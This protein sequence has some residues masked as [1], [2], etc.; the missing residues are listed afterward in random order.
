MTTKNNNN[1]LVLKNSLE[2]LSKPYKEQLNSYPN[3]VDVFD[4]VISDFGDA[5]LLLPV[6]MDEN[7]I[8]YEAVKEILKC[9]NLIDLNLSIEERR[10]DQSFES[11]QSWD[12]VRKLSKDALDLLNR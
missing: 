4:E 9:N 5:F 10:T 8:S 12:L 2:N 11:D 3:F 7:S 1:F 6:L